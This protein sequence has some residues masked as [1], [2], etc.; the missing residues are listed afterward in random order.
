[1]EALGWQVKAGRG[2]ALLDSPCR[3]AT[4][5]WSQATWPRYLYCG[6]VAAGGGGLQRQ[7]PGVAVCLPGLPGPPLAWIGVYDPRLGG[8]VV[9]ARHVPSAPALGSLVEV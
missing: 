9:V 5:S 4:A 2:F 1:M 6:A 7:G 8:A 3:E